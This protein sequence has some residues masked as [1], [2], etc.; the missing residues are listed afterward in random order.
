MTL[1]YETTKWIRLDDI[2]TPTSYRELGTSTA[3]FWEDILGSKWVNTNRAG[4]YQVSLTRPKDIVHRDIGYTGKSDCV[5]KRLSDL[6]T[7]AGA[8][9]KTAHHMCGVYL[10]EENIKVSDVYVRCLS[11]LHVA[12]IKN[13]IEFMERWIHNEHKKRFGYKVGY[14]WEEASGGYKSC[15]IQTQMS[16]KR[17]ESLE[18]CM[19]VQK[20]LNEQIARLKNGS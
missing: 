5:P 13:S 9:H 11:P 16:I 3:S 15:R 20:V 12:S 1:D 6:R 19:K 14:A 7:S 17:L 18:A 2:P 8:G 4:V 10:R